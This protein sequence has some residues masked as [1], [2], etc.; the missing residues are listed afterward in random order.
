MAWNDLS[1]YIY[2]KRKR[3]ARAMSDFKTHFI[4]LSG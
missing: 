4:F 3:D 1:P 2:H